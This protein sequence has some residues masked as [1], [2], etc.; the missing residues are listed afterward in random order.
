MRSLSCFHSVAGDI[1]TDVIINGLSSMLQAIRNFA[2][3][4]LETG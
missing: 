4:A 3:E 1:E 2:A